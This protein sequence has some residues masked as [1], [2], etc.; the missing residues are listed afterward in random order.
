MQPTGGFRHKLIT[1]EG[2]TTLGPTKI[3]SVFQQGTAVGTV[4]LYNDAAAAA[5]PIM[6]LGTSAAHTTHVI[7]CYANKGLVVVATGTPAVTLFI[8]P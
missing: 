4:V 1:A 2:T 7:D 8:D 6:T 5:D 3:H